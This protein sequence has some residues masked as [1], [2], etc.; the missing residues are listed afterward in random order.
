MEATDLGELYDTAKEEILENMAK[1]SS[2]GSNWKVSNILKIDINMINY[3]PLSASSWIELDEFLTSKKAI[4]NIQNEDNEHF[5]WCVTRALKM[6]NKNNERID[7]KLV[8]K[9]K[10]FNWERIEFPVKLNQIEKFENNNADISVS[11]FGFENKKPYPLKKLKYFGRKH[12]I[13]LLLISNKMTN[14]YC[15]IND[16]SRLMSSSTSAH[17]HKT[18]YCRNCLQGYISEEALSK[19]W[20]YCNEHSCVRVEL[21]KKDSSMR[22][23]HIERSMRV[24]F[25][26]YADFESFIKPINTFDPD[27]KQSFT[28]QYQKHTPSSFC[29]YIKC[30]DDTVYKGKPVTYTASSETDDVACKFVEMLEED[31]IEIYERTKFPK[32]MI[33]TDE[34]KKKYNNEKVCHICKESLGNDKVRDHCHLTGKY[35]GAAHNS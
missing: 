3:N 2:G 9:S 13:D 23:T 20:T 17:Q 14:H 26:V 18:Y 27:E 10:E 28:K 29:Y 5:K 25:E 32:K 4:I 15:L 19:H 1:Y 12:H 35:R 22:F 33:I 34:N 30:F 24:P 7:K 16:F 11:V 21:P 8:E 31:I 6:K